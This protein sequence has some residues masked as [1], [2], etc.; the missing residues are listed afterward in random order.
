[1]LNAPVESSSGSNVVT[2]D[3]VLAV[4]ESPAEQKS[5]LIRALHS[6][7]TPEVQ[8]LAAALLGECG[9][10]DAD[11]T[12]ALEEAGRKSDDPCLVLAVLDSQLH[13][14]NSCTGT[15]SNL[16]RLLPVSD[17]GVQIQGVTSLRHFSGTESR[18]ECVKYLSGL[19]DSGDHDLRA[20]AVLALGDM[21]P[22]PAATIERL[23]ELS[24]EDE[25]DA[26]RE[27]A[28]ATLARPL[29]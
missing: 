9:G 23:E 10:K 17:S 11:V 13:Q 12:A 7:D 14:G 16:L 24:K 28:A 21:G 6:G 2:L 15:A 8:C 18:S 4:V 27:S 22:L 20:A 3:D 26:V 1:M 29:K 19:L 25:C 5:L